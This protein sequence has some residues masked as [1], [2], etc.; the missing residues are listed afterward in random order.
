MC[1]GGSGPRKDPPYDCG[2]TFGADPGRTATDCNE[3]QS[4][5][6]RQLVAVDWLAVG[7]PSSAVAAELNIARTTLWRWRQD[8]VFAA[9]FNARR[10]ELWQPS[11]DRLRALL[12]RALDVL[13]EAVDGGDWKAAA[14]VVRLGR[15]G[16]TDL[17]RVGLTDPQAIQDAD[18]AAAARR[19]QDQEEE[20]VSE[21]GR[22]SYLEL[23]RMLVGQ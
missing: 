13:G 5:D 6:E 3:T 15:V 18:A 8:P 14:A 7:R 1:L 11:T 20:A 12:S 19:E 17:G 21:A 22:E 2:V 16:D 10:A 4:L 9:E 23:R